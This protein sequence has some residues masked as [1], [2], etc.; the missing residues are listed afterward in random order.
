[1]QCSTSFH[2]QCLPDGITAAAVEALWTKALAAVPACSDRSALAAMAVARTVSF[3]ERAL[4]TKFTRL[5]WD[6]WWPS[7]FAV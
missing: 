5:G 4:A 3:R 2:D 6:P 7:C 1:M